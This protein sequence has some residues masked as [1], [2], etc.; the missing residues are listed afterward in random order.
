[1]PELPDVEVFRRRIAET[2]L[3][4]AIERTSV[5]ETSTLDEGTTA[6]KLARRLK[7]NAFERVGRH[8]KYLLA[9]VAGE[10]LVLHFG[11]TGYPAFVEKGGEL[12]EHTRIEFRFRD[13]SSLAYVNQRL[14]GHVFLVP[15]KRNLLDRK[16]L[17]PDAWEIDAD[18]FCER[19]GQKGRGTLKSALMDQ[20]TIAGIGN[21]YSDEVLFQ[22]RLHPKTP[23][24]PLD[25]SDLKRTHRVLHRVLKVCVRHEVDL[26]AL[27]RGYL[28]PHREG[29]GRCPR[30]DGK[31][32]KIA[33]SGR[34][35]LYCP[36]CQRL[37]RPE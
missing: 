1:M 36:S 16:D 14:L 15:A 17:G 8:G 27:P 37:R 34:N 5:L 31:L 32:Q 2:S 29:D 23:V 4:R 11:M 9:G 35:A 26:D 12:P 19:I 13:G 33:V 28:V 6:Q 30:C 21:V 18:E 25:R 22:M 7:G 10:Q 3:Q 20:S 24:E